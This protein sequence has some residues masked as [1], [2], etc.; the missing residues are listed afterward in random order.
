MRWVETTTGMAVVERGYWKMD[1]LD[2]LTDRNRTVM[3]LILPEPSREKAR[4]KTSS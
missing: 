3:R 2:H 4:P 1:S